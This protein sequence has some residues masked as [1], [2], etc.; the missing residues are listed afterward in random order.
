MKATAPAFGVPNGDFDRCSNSAC[1]ALH[2][3]GGYRRRGRIDWVAL[4]ALVPLSVLAQD[5]LDAVVVN[6][7]MELTSSGGHLSS[8]VPCELLDLT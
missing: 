6:R 2:L 1:L 3:S 7:R 8:L 4:L 5:L